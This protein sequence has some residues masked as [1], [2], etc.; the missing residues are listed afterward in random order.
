[1]RG[2]AFPIVPVLMY[3]SVADEPPASPIAPLATPVRVFE[4]MMAHLHRRRFTTISLAELHGHLSTGRPL[5]PRPIVLTF[6]DG[7]LDNWVNAFPILQKFAFRATIFVVPE[8]VDPSPEPRPTLLDVWQGRA[9]A[10]DLAHR[11]FLSWR[12]M[13]VMA[14]SGLVDIQSHTLT[15]TCLFQGP[16]VVD[17]HRPGA[18]YPWLAWNRH[19]TRKPRWLTEPQEELVPFGAPIYAHGRA[20][21]APAYV[22]DDGLEAAL[23]AYV[24]RHGGLAFFRTAAWRNRLGQVAADHRARRP[25]AGI[26]ETWTQYEA[27]VSHELVESKAVIER[28]VGQRVNFLCWPGGAQNDTTHALAREAG[29]QATTKGSAKNAWGAD[30]GRIHRISGNV[31]LARIHPLADAVGRLPLFALTVGAYRGDPVHAR[32]RQALFAAGRA[33]RAAVGRRSA[34]TA[35]R[36]SAPGRHARSSALDEVGRRA[37]E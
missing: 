11:G 21:G 36:H 9:R 37:A 13:Q 17:F 6:D 19:P 10:A 7:Y 31:S 23:T 2:E 1:M 20:L 25:S 12:E 8:F 3:H 33:L 32:L 28:H 35:A 5:P 16:A 24:E 18:G 14:R 34:T 26:Y 27:R 15:H 29:Y 22:P 4:R 30:A